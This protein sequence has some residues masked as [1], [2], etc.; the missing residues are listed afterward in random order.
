MRAA[1]AGRSLDTAQK[2]WEMRNPKESAACSSRIR[3]RTIRD[4]ATMCFRVRI[5]VASPP[6]DPQLIPLQ[7]CRPTPNP[8]AP[9]VL[10]GGSL[11]LLGAAA[12]RGSPLLLSGVVGGG[13]FAA[14]MAKLQA[15]FP[16]WASPVV[17]AGSV[18][19]D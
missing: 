17:T 5:L 6:R 2:S 8:G 13:F 19:K 1:M 15:R 18:L 14:I 4:T 16:C 9:L 10:V 7:V 11:M 3:H 12:H